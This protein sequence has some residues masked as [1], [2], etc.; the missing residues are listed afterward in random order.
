[1]KVAHLTGD[2]NYFEDF[3]VGAVMRHG[4]GKTMSEMENVMFTNLVLNTADAHFDE[5]LMSSSPTGHRI[6]YGGVTASLVIGLASQ[7]TSENAI[8]ELGLDS[9][10]LTAPVL[11]GDTIYVE[12]EVLTVSDAVQPDAGEVCFRHTGNNQ[13]GVVVCEAVRRV[14]IKRRSHWSDR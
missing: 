9:L 14:L 3:S 5:H 7:D 13:N 1:M 4:R 11:H 8:R 6:V 12:T 10:K 2:R